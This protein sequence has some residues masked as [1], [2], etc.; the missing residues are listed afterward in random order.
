MKFYL[1]QWLRQTSNTWKRINLL[2]YSEIPDAGH[3]QRE[4]M[5]LEGQWVWA[6]WA[7]PYN[8]SNVK[9]SSRGFLSQ[10]LLWKWQSQFQQ[11]LV[12]ILPNTSNIILTILWAFGFFL[13]DHPNTNFLP[14]L[15]NYK[16]VVN[17]HIH[18]WLFCHSLL[19]INVCSIW[20]TRSEGGTTCRSHG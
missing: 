14:L 5:G 10:V 4:D 6:G 8:Q 13:T 17:S 19:G 3:L 2:S 15:Q 9:K 18:K 12:L 7:V 20:W 1:W 11:Y 16:R